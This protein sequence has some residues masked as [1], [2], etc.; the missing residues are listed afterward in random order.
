MVAVMWTEPAVGAAFVAGLAGLV[1]AVLGLIPHVGRL[2]RL[3]RVVSIL[4]KIDDVEA[5]APLI[6]LRDRLCCSLRPR[7]VP[8]GFG[9]LL[10]VVFFLSSLIAVG[11]GVALRTFGS[12]SSGWSSALILGGTV[13]LI[14]GLFV[15]FFALLGMR[16]RRLDWLRTAVKRAHSTEA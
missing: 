9:F 16:R 13:L 5:R 11:W 7:Q 15:L 1:A 6:E 3:E 2:H 4:E 10:A 12:D 14:G 8:D